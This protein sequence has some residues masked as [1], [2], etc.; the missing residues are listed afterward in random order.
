[1]DLICPPSRKFSQ[2]KFEIGLILVCWK[3]P[4][5]GSLGLMERQAFR[6]NRVEIS[7]HKPRG[8]SMAKKEISA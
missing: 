4:C 2:A 6:R 1:M 5:L 8:D 7:D 3:A